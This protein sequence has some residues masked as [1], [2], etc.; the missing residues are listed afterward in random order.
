MTIML[1]AK[2]GQRISKTHEA[3]ANKASSSH[4]RE[5]RDDA[6]VAPDA[7]T[8]PNTVHSNLSFPE[9]DVVLDQ[10]EGVFWMYMKPIGR[11]SFTPSLL[12]DMRRALD[13]VE[14]RY[15]D[16]SEHDARIRWVVMASAMPGIFN[17]GGDLPR[18]AALIR[19]KDRDAL[20]TYAHA[21]IDV[22]YPRSVNLNL[23]YIGISL[24]QGDALGGGFECAL[25]DDVIIAERSA[26]FGLPEI[27]FSLFPGMGALSFLT[28]KIGR[29]KAEELVLSGRIYTAEQM[30]E[31][32]VVD[33]VADDGSGEMAVY[34]F[35]KSVGR[36]FEARRCV[37]QARQ[38][39]HPVS[40][41]E[42]L[43][44]TDSWVEAALS[45]G[46]LDLRKMER[47]AAAQDRRHAA[48]TQ[49]VAA[50]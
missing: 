47:L 13:L 26:K 17:L 33:I 41:E 12:R 34:D 6:L 20:R 50:G 49:A 16:G 15:R 3:I 24:V 28:R 25:A 43:A 4:L 14:L 32:G 5:R 35:I 8:N 18:F 21:C 22:Q 11:P 19:D 29:V 36:T 38:A 48:G 42:M 7:A 27:L 45:L 31:I 30:H 40:R 37:L 46:P 2:Q 44:I 10:S 1:P 39:V 9:L 23:P